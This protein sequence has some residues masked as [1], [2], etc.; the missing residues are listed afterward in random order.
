MEFRIHGLEA[1][2]G[3]APEEGISAIKI[4]AEGTTN[5]NLGRIDPETTANIG[6]IEGGMATNIIPNL[7]VLKGEARSHSEDKLEA[8]TAHMK[9]CLEDA[10][11]K[12]EETVE[13]KPTK[14]DG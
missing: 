8:Q 14:A 11:A 13:G 2:A 5:M 1:H 3:V 7:V 10:A 9:K 12:Y 6:Q 4:A